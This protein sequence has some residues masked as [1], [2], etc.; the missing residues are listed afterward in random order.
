[1][2][3]ET[4]KPETGGHGGENHG[5]EKRDAN[6]PGLLIFGVGLAVILIVSFVSMKWALDYFQRTEPL[7]PPASP[8]AKAPVKA[9]GPMLQ[10]HPHQDLV[11]YC[12]A[13]E[14]RLDNYGWVDQSA[15]IVRIPVERAMELT[16][17]RGL[18]TRPASEAPG[19]SE[20]HQVGTV[21]A[22]LPE[23]VGGPCGYLYRDTQKAKSGEDAM[24][25]N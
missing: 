20:A 13:Q 21:E 25:D 22:P 15:G 19:G 12:T 17:E 4:K 16:L 3:M 1:M 7:G 9:V 6:I 24:P 23:G 5:Y 2:S 14:E 11:D 18:P 8:V 10:A